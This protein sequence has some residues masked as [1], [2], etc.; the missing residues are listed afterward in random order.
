VLVGF[1]AL[2]MVGA[3]WQA[4][5]D[6]AAVRQFSFTEFWMVPKA[7]SKLAIGIRSDERKEQAFDIE[8]TSAPEQSASK[9][10]GRT[11]LAE[12]HGIVVKP[13]DSWTR[14][15]DLSPTMGYSKAE[16]ILYLSQDHT[17]YR[18]VSAITG[19]K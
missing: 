19:G 14:E 18:R 3:F 7:Y 10:P 17:I 1:A 16:A 11:V 13:G 8:V 5:R 12:W 9:A 6:E 15:V 2:L 4:V